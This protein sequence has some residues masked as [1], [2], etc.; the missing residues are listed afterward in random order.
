MWYNPSLQQLLFLETVLEE[1]T[2]VRAANRLHTTHSTI[3]R[4]LKAL[5][6]GL[7]MNLFDK[8]PKGLTLNEIGRVYC[9]EVRRALDQSRR[10]FDLAQYQMQMDRLPFR[11]GHSPYIHG[12]ILPLLNH[13][14]LPGTDAPP[15]VL[16]SATTMQIVQR[17]LSGRLDA[18]FGVLPIVDKD[19]WIERIA[20]ESF[21][22]FMVEHHNLVRHPKLSARNLRDEI[23]FWIPRE[24]HRSLYDQI[25]GYLRT[26]DFDP[27][28]F[29]EAHAITQ[30]LDFAAAGAGIALVPYSAQR[31]NRSGVVFRPLTDEL[32]RI[33]TALFVRRKQMLETAKDFIGIVF[34]ATRALKLSP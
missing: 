33:E 14:S 27:R 29:R 11:V 2:L 30:A 28:Q 3:S 16:E 7:G 5:C 34:A 9:V 10:A 18:G 15:V 26:L 8:T 32:M 22:T 4:G 31:F 23:I 12:Q 13:F 17:V 19:L 6:S 21:A 20:C 1:G 25:V 24:I